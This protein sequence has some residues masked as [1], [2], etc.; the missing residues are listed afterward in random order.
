VIAFSIFL[1]LLCVFCRNFCNSNQV[2]TG[3]HPNAATNQTNLGFTDSNANFSLD[4]QFSLP[5][6]DEAIKESTKKET[7]FI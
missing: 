5:T 2:N 1:V 7:T 4:R 6:Y 3:Q